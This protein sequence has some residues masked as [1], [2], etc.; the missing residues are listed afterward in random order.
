MVRRR[1]SDSDAASMDSL[2]DT[3]T[4]VVGIQIIMLASLQLDVSAT[5]QRIQGIDPLATAETVASMEKEAASL[6]ARQKSLAEKA[7]Q[8][9]PATMDARIKQMTEDISKLRLVLAEPTESKEDPEKI[10][11]EVENLKQSTADAET[12][13]EDQE[14]AIAGKRA[15]LA[16][17]KPMN[18]PPAKV[19]GLPNPRAVPD[20]FKP[21]YFVCYQGRVAAINIDAAIQ[22]VVDTVKKR[23]LKAEAVC[24]CPRAAEIFKQESLGNES[25]LLEFRE[26]N[27]APHMVVKLREGEGTILR[28]LNRPNSSFK[29]DLQQI[30][31]TQQFARFL[32]WPDSHEIYLAA[33]R[34]CDERDIPAGWQPMGPQDEWILNLQG[35]FQCEGYVPPPPAPPPPPNKKP[36]P[37]PDTVD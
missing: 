17:I 34:E 12:K 7:A 9:D 25:F 36:P 32:V 28:L 33:R 13:L 18:G 15:Q 2:M 26:I 6:A 37:P 14:K 8:V 1:G 19:I 5:V 20:N 30:D 35:Y 24:D 22:F 10:K 16:E 29:K 3:L 21:V 4:N 31:T 27:K 11:Q 23:A